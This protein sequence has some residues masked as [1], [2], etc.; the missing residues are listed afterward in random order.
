MP[1]VYSNSSPSCPADAAAMTEAAGSLPRPG[2]VKPAPNAA[3][4][5]QGWAIVENQTDSDWTDVQLSLVSGRPISFIQHLYLPLY[6]PRPVVWPEL[7]AS[8]RPQTY[9]GG[10]TEQ[11][12][13]KLRQPGRGMMEGEVAEMDGADAPDFSLQQSSGGEDGEAGRASGGGGQGQGGGR[14]LFGRGGMFGGGGRFGNTGGTWRDNG[15]GDAGAIDPAASVI[16]AASAG[17]LGELFQ[18]T[19]GNVTLPRQRSAMIPIVTDAL[20]VERVSIYNHAVLPNHPLT[21][22]RLKNTT[23]KHLLQGPVTVLDG[24]AYAGDARIDDVP[25][26]QERLLSYGIDLQVRVQREEPEGASTIQRAQVAGGVLTIDRREVY[27]QTYVAQNKSTVDKQMVFEV[28]SV[29][30]DYRLVEPARADEKTEQLY[31]FRRPVAAGQTVRFK[32][33]MDSP[34]QSVVRLD[35]AELD[36]LEAFVEGDEMPAAVREALAEPLRLRRAISDL[37]REINERQS[38]IAATAT[39]QQRMRDNM[40]AVAED[41]EYY[42]RLLKKLD[43]QE[44]AIETIQREIADRQAKQ[45]ATVKQLA[46]HLATLKVDG[47]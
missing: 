39:E 36:D 19:V 43:E 7:Y 33:V 22:A 11:A 42:L 28:A 44:T 23:G 5:L 15:G 10:I 32:V 6:A 2:D 47:V 26:G 4:K 24:G 30:D 34:V 21:G 45:A 46:E 13:A 40:A 29:G 35:R 16:A 25:P 8:L 37:A 17:Q 1:T 38:K 9:E 20:E 27:A 31:R 3:A 18:Y 14:G 41:S 12:L